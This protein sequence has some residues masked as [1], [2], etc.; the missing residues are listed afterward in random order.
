MTI[1]V[2]KPNLVSVPRSNLE[3]LRP[4][5]AL[6]EGGLWYELGSVGLENSQ[7]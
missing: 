1:F 6:A 2:I 5:G 3:Q 4:I 7:D